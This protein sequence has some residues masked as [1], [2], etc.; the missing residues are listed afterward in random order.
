MMG[1]IPRPLFALFTCSLMVSGTIIDDIE[2]VLNKLKGNITENFPRTKVLPTSLGDLLRKFGVKANVSQGC[3][4]EADLCIVE[5]YL[6]NN[7]S[8]PLRGYCGGFL[9]TK[10]V[11]DGE[12]RK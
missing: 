2:E 4:F 3:P 7:N 5:C 12:Y 6:N 11:C 1:T 10:C 9:W 8:K